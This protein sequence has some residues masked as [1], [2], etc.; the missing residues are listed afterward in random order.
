MNL[1]M[2]WL[3]EFVP[4]NMEPRAFAEA[5][6]MSGSKVEGWELSLIHI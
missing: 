2:R 1:S 3:K 6:T 5:M 4:V